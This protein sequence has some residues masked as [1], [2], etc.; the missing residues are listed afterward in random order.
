[1]V[2]LKIPLY[3]HRKSGVSGNPGFLVVLVLVEWNL[4]KTLVHEV[5]RGMLFVVYA[6]VHDFA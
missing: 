1:M 5:D 4:K 2:F 6:R 3:F